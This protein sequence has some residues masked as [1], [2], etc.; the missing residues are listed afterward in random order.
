VSHSHL[1]FYENAIEVCLA[2]GEIER[3]QRYVQALRQ[4]TRREPLPWSEFL[5]RRALALAAVAGGQTS[6]SVCEELQALAQ[7]A[8]AA[9]LVTALPGIEAALSRMG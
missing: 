4:Y 9:G 3:A 1:H 8:E 5:V 7:E 2:G 6:D